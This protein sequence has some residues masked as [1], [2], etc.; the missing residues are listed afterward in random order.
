[1]SIFCFDTNLN[2]NRYIVENTS[3]DTV[4]NLTLNF[5]KK[6]HTNIMKNIIFALKR[7]NQWQ[8][9]SINTLISTPTQP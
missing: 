6:T 8:K 3:I 9:T 7:L 4:K 5:M 2:S 1:M